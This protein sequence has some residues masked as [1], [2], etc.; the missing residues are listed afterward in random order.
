MGDRVVILNV[1]LADAFGSICHDHLLRS[2]WT[3]V[4]P[5]TAAAILKCVSGHRFRPSWMN[6]NGEPVAI[7]KGCRQGAPEVVR[8]WSAKGCGVA[9]PI[10]TVGGRNWHPRNESDASQRLHHMVPPSW[11]T[12]DAEAQNM[13]MN[14]CAAINPRRF[15]TKDAKLAV[16]SNFGA[17]P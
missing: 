8:G 12:N 10:T 13:Y 16:W 15:R 2:P 7:A 14:M 17:H 9:L 5:V 3:R 6:L 11:G 1:D 4:R